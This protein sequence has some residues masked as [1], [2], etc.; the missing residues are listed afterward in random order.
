ME[1]FEIVNFVLNPGKNRVANLTIRYHELH[2][3][4]QLMLWKNEKLWIKFPEYNMPDK[5][6][7][8]LV[9]WP[10]KAKSDD[11]QN[12]L[13]KKVFDNYAMNLTEALEVVKNSTKKVDDK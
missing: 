2:L 4:C 8:R 11:V 3:C 10:D 9:W 1:E 12:F 6:K 5:K 13:L 7:F